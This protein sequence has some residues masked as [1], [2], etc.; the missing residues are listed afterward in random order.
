MNRKQVAPAL[1]Q[2]KRAHRATRQA[3]PGSPMRGTSQA[4]KPTDETDTGPYARTAIGVK[5]K[6]I[7]NTHG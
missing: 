7:R 1:G 5:F 3:Q 2:M 4:S 6:C